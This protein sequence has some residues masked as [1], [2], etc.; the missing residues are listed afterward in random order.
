[1]KVCIFGDARSVHIR[2]IACGLA[3]RDV[4]VHVV[5][6]KAGEVPSATVERFH[7]PTASLTNPRRW[8]SR[9]I[10][11]LDGFM[12]RYDVVQVHFLHD[13][14][15][16]PDVISRGCF[17]ASPWGSDIVPPPGEDTP[18]TSLRE[19][20]ISMLRSAAAVTALGPGFAGV[21]ADY[22]GIEKERIDLLPLGV[23]LEQFRPS[24][25][26]A[27][28]RKTDF[29]VGFFKGFREVYGPTYLIRAIPVVLE[30]LPTTKFHLVGDGPQLQYCRLL[31]QEL[32][33]DDCIEWLPR[34]DHSRMP[35]YIARWDLTVIP[36]VC[37]SFGLAALESSAMGVPVVASDVGGLPETVRHGETGLLVPPEE[38]EAMAQA[39]IRLLNDH[40]L[41]RRMG[42]SGRKL[43]EREYDW[44]AILDKWVLTYRAALDRV[45][46]MV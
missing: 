44:Q 16:T 17:M 38:P 45:A 5:T 3:K 25:P 12:R 24:S 15:F 41:R 29:K 21:V 7:I 13:W 20:R 18:S 39:V 2:R 14:G 31:A 6:A 35:H 11:Y 26:L 19:S 46:V 22:A 1:M 37:E 43:V 30:R 23:D 9:W 33:V 40:D 28:H 4:N 34:Q 8:R 10:R 32:G 42:E 36:S 27:V